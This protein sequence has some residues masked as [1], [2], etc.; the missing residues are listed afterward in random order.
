VLTRCV[1]PE[2]LDELPPTDPRAVRSRRDLVRINAW[3]G[4]SRTM[5]QALRASFQDPGPERMIELGAGDGEFLLRVARRLP[6]SPRHRT[7]VLVDRQPAVS[8]Q[9]QQ[10]F[11][12]HGWRAELVKADVFDW[13]AQPAADGRDA[14]VA[15]LFLHH[16][17]EVQLARL[18]AEVMR[19]AKLFVAIEPRR[20]GWPLGCSCLLWMIGCNHVTRHDALISVRAGF[21][22]RELSHLWP[23]NG[24]WSLQERRAGWWSHLFIA[25]RI[26]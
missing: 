9:T 13:L 25:R 1:E 20:A 19:H 4:N 23:A 14:L 2:L 5:A 6:R 15:N 17:A 7:A 26:E 3:M 22:G 10:A 16:F 12:A 8:A 24:S 11:A 18:L 21:A